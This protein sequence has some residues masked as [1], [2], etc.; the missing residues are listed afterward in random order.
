M[1]QNCKNDVN[2]NAFNQLD[3]VMTRKFLH[4]YLLCLFIGFQFASNAQSDSLS[5][6]QLLRNQLTYMRKT[7]SLVRM[8]LQLQIE[9]LK[10]QKVIADTLSK[11]LE[12]SHSKNHI[13][14]EYSTTVDILNGFPVVPFRDTLFFVHLRFGSLRPAERA[15]KITHRIQQLYHD[16]ELILDSIQSISDGT[17]IDIVYGDLIIMSI[18]EMDAI[19]RNKTIDEV[20]TEY[21]QKIKQTIKEEQEE[22]SFKTILIRI[23]LILLVLFGIYAL[24]W[25][26]NKA[27]KQINNLIVSK[28]EDWIKEIKYR[29]YVFF[30]PEQELRWAL[31]ISNFLKWISVA[32]LLY[33]AIPMLFSIFPFTRGV[34]EK[35]FTLIW[36]PFKTIFISIW[37]Y[38]PNLITILVIYIVMYYFIKFIRFIFSEIESGKLEFAGFHQ[39]W[40]MPT[41]SIVK[42]LLYAFML[43]L[44]F[45]YLPGNDSE[46]FK[47]V[48]VFVGILF[49]LGSSSAISNMVAG[50]VITYMRPFKVGDRIT[51][52]DKTGIVIEKTLL[53]TR[54]R[55]IKNEEITIPNSS[56]LSGNTVNFSTL[57]KSKGLILH[58]TVTIGYDVPWKNVHKALIDAAA[59][60]HRIKQSP[61]PFVLQTSLDDFYVAYQI[62]G[63]TQDVTAAAEIYSDLHQNIQDVFNERGIEIMS[64][65]Y[66]AQRD[67]NTTTIPSDY[68]PEDYRSPGFEVNLNDSKE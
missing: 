67:G 28:K 46:I 14:T 48:S 24:I 36:S 52:G 34:A 7:D 68:L 16:D 61:K 50:L 65:H 4:F 10:M 49:S 53:V 9:E 40:A 38:V 39:D 62:N 66:R 3:S 59:R 1:L 8:E 15:L 13:P 22:H 43:V 19:I 20:A 60:V 41:F 23:A 30:T 5:E 29:S 55:T 51:L 18:T 37:N 6:V 31:K 54:L 45:P 47:G 32:I 56:V 44:I 42:I 17:V 57:S 27:H 11:E 58:T 63:Y 64:P 25:L 21:L 35:M 12:H 26:L 33:L 2:W